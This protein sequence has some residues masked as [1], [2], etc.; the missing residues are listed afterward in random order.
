MPAIEV[1][2]EVYA[3]KVFMGYIYAVFSDDNVFCN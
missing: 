2:C 1:T 3:G